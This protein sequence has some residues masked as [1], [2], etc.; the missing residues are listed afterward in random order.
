MMFIFTSKFQAAITRVLVSVY[1]KYGEGALSLNIN[2]IR[3]V[4]PKQLS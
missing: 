1:S 3:I 4:S 2:P